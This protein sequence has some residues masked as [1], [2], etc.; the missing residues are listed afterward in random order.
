MQ[1]LE[2]QNLGDDIKVIE[3]VKSYFKI[4]GSRGKITFE[5]YPGDQNNFAYLVRHV[6][7]NNS[8]HELQACFELNPSNWS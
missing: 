1:T 2:L 5:H 4:T 3:Y 7:H 8:R 6:M